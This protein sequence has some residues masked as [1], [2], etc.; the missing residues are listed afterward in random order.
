MKLFCE[1]VIDVFGAEY[2]RAPT[3]DDIKIIMCINVTRGFL[4]FVG[5]INFHHYEWK[6]YPV[7]WVGQLKGKEK[8]P[9]I[10]M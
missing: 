2:L 1:R 3:E 6:N 9:T 4:E 5:S 10:V 8:N 7:D